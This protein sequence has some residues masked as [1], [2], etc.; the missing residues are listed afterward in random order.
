MLYENFTL[1]PVNAEGLQKIDEIF[2][3]LLV[4][5]FK[6]N[7]IVQSFLHSVAVS[8]NSQEI[9]AESVQEV[10]KILL[11]YSASF[12]VEL[13]LWK[14]IDDFKTLNPKIHQIVLWLLTNYGNVRLNAFL[15]VNVVFSLKHI[16][17]NSIRK[18]LRYDTK[19]LCAHEK[20]ASLGL[21]DSM[22]KYVELRE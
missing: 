5:K 2:R 14:Q 16:C 17:R 4:N 7:M 8:R 22:I 1:R 3:Y 10:L 11:Y 6:L 9:N 21:P 19:V 13:D 20:L 12:F 18:K 15:D